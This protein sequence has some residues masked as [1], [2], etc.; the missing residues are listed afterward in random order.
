MLASDQTHVP[1]LPLPLL[2]HGGESVPELSQAVHDEQLGD[3]MNEDESG[4]YVM[5]TVAVPV[6]I[7]RMCCPPTSVRCNLHRRL[8]FRQCRRPRSS[9][10]SN[11]S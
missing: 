4:A 9:K 6:P 7:L 5:F 11:M 8:L 2:E 1:P 10:L 3:S